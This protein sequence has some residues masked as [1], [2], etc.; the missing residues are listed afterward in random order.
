MVS[1]CWVEKE[2][3]TIIQT[4]EPS[5]KFKKKKKIVGLNPL[6]TINFTP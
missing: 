2:D 5:D 1:H 4:N 3:G 6:M